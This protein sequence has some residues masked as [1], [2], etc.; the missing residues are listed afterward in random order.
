MFTGLVQTVGRIA[1]VRAKGRSARLTVESEFEEELVLGESVAVDGACLTVARTVDSGFEA[2]LSPETLRRTTA[3]TWKRGRRVNLE[4]SLR[5]TDRLG[6]H[7]VQGHVDARGR[8]VLTKRGRGQ[9]TLRVEFPQTLSGLIAEK[10][11]IAVDGVSLTVSA[12]A[13]GWF[14]TALIPH[15]L[16]ATTL[17]E[18]RAGDGVNLE[19]DLI[20][21]YLAR[22]LEETAPRCPKPSR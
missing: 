19:A 21:R 17:G 1:A 20:A 10:G 7:L 8:V 18:R 9:T 12:L 3:G 13:E 16:N 2:D 14:E 4:R 22:I 5:P 6:G 11:S 15:T